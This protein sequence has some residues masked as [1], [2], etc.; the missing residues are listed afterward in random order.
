M[1]HIPLIFRQSGRIPA[2]VTNDLMVSNYDFL[3]TVL[4]QLGLGD[5]MPNRPKSP[6]RDFSA[7]LRGEKI[8]WDN[9]MFYEM[10]TVRAVRTDDWK[11]VARFPNGPF[12]LYD[13]K[14]DPRERF[15]LYGQ[16]GMEAR[17]DELAQR[18]DA[19]FAHHA[20]PHYNL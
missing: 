11:Y 12:E 4:S 15:N 5:K 1:M 17:R 10:E 6:G 2:G 9:V 18:L 14:K 8:A 7:V 16:P 13:M 19:F 20:D 3:P